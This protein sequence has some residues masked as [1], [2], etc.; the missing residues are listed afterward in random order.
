[1][2]PVENGMRIEILET[3]CRWIQKHHSFYHLAA[4]NSEC[5]FLGQFYSFY[6]MLVDVYTQICNRRL[7]SG[8][9]WCGRKSWSLLLTIRCH[10]STI[11]LRILLNLNGDDQSSMNVLI[12]LYTF[13]VHLFTF[14]RFI[15]L[16]MRITKCG[17]RF[18]FCWSANILAIFGIIWCRFTM[19]IFTLWTEYS[20]IK[21]MPQIIGCGNKRQL[22]TIPHQ[23]DYFGITSKLF[24]NVM[25]PASWIL[26]CVGLNSD[27]SYVDRFVVSY[28]E[29]NWSSVQS[30]SRGTLARS[31]EY[32]CHDSEW[33]WHNSEIM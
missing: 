5:H 27:P 23:K 7:S 20:Y 24:G 26:V 6:I 18:L 28:C 1:M 29:M 25:Q 15:Y 11:W 12:F 9:V 2:I 4:W 3:T 17:N 22:I 14:I 32:F 30:V 16:K 21:E 13:L 8:P 19:F 31:W 33:F 10:V